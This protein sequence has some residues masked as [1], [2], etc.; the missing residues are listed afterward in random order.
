MNIN[1]EQT[2]SKTFYVGN[3]TVKILAINPTNE[4]KAKMFGSEVDESKLE[5]EYCKE[6]EIKIGENSEIVNQVGI[7]V[8][9]QEQKT[10]KILPIIFNLAQH[11]AN[12]S[13]DGKKLYLNSLGGSCYAMSEGDLPS[14][15]TTSA[16]KDKKTG[17]PQSLKREIREAMIGEKELYTFLQQWIQPNGFSSTDGVMCDQSLFLDLKKIFNGNFKELQDLL[18]NEV[19]AEMSVICA[20]GVKTKEDGTIQQTISNKFFLK[21]YES[22]RLTNMS[23]KSTG[24]E[25][26]AAL[27]A[28]KDYDLKRFSKDVND[29]EHGYSTKVFYQFCP[30]KE[31]NPDENPVS[32]NEAV[33]IEDSQKEKKPWDN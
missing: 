28:S 32:T 1:K 19:I 8:Y 17:E 9:V 33:V 26:I 12:S 3:G 25:D 18:K 14:W 13:K 6:G 10:K 22:L 11:T 24:V 27:T 23:S 7:W 5:P 20:F 31:Y 16:W 30:L 2:E 29:A 21:G 15:F 4:Q